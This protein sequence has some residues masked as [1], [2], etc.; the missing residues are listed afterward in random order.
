MVHDLYKG[1][2]NVPYSVQAVLTGEVINNTPDNVKLITLMVKLL[3]LDKEVPLQGTLDNTRI[4]ILIPI[5]RP[6][7]ISP[8]TVCAATGYDVTDFEVKVNGYTPTTDTLFYK[9][10]VIEP[11]GMIESFDPPMDINRC[12]NPI[13][14]VSGYVVRGKVNNTG[15]REARFVQVICTFYDDSGDVVDAD[16]QTLDNTA[17]LSPGHE[18]VFTMGALCAPDLISDFKIQVIAE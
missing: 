4:E 16:K 9:L 18:D 3:Q 6:G 13:P 7:E 1:N 12:A 14:L 5:L 8:F 17:H 15:E 11:Q 2:P 10:K